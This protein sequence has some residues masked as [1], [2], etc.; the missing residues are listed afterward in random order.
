V[1]E[2][3]N[4]AFIF[5]SAAVLVALIA[6]CLLWSV[7]GGAATCARACGQGRMMKWSPGSQGV[8]EQCLCEGAK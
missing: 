4:M 1:N 6:S 3:A 5:M 7:F 8:V 2:R